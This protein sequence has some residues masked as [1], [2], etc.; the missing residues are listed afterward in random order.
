MADTTQEIED[1][2]FRTY[3]DK[4]DFDVPEAIDWDLLTKGIETL[5]NGKPFSS[6]I[7]DCDTQTRKDETQI[8]LPS[9]VIIVEGTLIFFVERV[10][11][12]LALKIYI[13][14]D[15][16]V[17][18]SRR[19][20]VEQT[21]FNQKYTIKDCIN[22][23]LLFVKPATEKYVEPTKIYADAIIPNYKFDDKQNLE[24]KQMLANMIINYMKVPNKGDID[25]EFKL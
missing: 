16:D 9:Q 19:I 10:R 5:L 1:E 24:S 8:I 11:K 21:K 3:L 18:L 14:T 12:L 15:N 22:K 23:Y 6:P 20:D 17:R 25:D 2:I 4:Y 13:E 7:Y